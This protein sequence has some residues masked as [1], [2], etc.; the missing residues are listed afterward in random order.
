MDSSNGELCGSS[1]VALA[2]QVVTDISDGK[3]LSW[4]M[5]GERRVFDS[6]EVCLSE[7]DVSLPTKERAWLPVVRLCSSVAV[8]LLDDGGRV[9]LVRRFRFVQG[10]RGWELPGDQVGED[11]DFEDA[12]RRGLE[13]L[14]GYRASQL[15]RLVAF[16]PAADL[17]DGERAI[18]L[19]RDAVA[20]GDPVALGSDESA[21]WV[22]LESVRGLIDEGEI[23]DG[24]SVVGLLS[25]LSTCSNV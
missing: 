7:V 9:M 6:P 5:F 8:A 21:E 1:H 11:E 22:P 13:D 25:V 24:M 18:F 12:A 20:A 19:A 10:R 16:Q 23:W 15:E 2:F 4:R 14:T 3:P 17:V